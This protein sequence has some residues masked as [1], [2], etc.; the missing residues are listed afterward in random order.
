[1]GVRGDEERGREGERGEKGE[2]GKEKKSYKTQS[3]FNAYTCCLI[4]IKA[5]PQIIF[6]ISTG[7]CV[8]N[9]SCHVIPDHTYHC[10][11]RGEAFL[12]VLAMSKVKDQKY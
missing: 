8:N 1:M 5:R 3:Y 12:N 2:R 11:W 10:V 9:K 7:I 6:R 4:S